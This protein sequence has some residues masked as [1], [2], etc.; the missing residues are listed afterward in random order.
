MKPALYL[1]TTNF[2]WDPNHVVHTTLESTIRNHQQY[3]KM[4]QDFGTWPV[5]V[6]GFKRDYDGLQDLNLRAA[7]ENRLQ[8]HRPGPITPCVEL[9]PLGYTIH[10]DFMHGSYTAGRA[11]AEQPDYD[12]LKG[13]LLLDEKSIGRIFLERAKAH[14]PQG[15]QHINLLINY[16]SNDTVYQNVLQ[17]LELDFQIT[18]ITIL[19]VQ[20]RAEKELLTKEQLQKEKEE[21]ER[22]DVEN[23]QKENEILEQ[24]EEDVALELWKQER[25][26]YT[27]KD[28]EYDRIQEMFDMNPDLKRKK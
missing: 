8:E 17:R 3:K 16:Y 27:E 15:Q 5:S 28:E 4:K 19:R 20:Y 14:L 23:C 26:A 7:L 25:E 1:V 12:T 18:P 11:S 9:A 2:D 24:K 6:P 10:T 13:M 21:Y 22:E